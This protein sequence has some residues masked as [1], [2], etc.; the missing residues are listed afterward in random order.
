[1]YSLKWDEELD[2]HFSS[3]LLFLLGIIIGKAIFERIPVNCF[4]DRTIIRQ[5]CNQSVELA[6]IYGY[7]KEVIVFL[8]FSFIKIGKNVYKQ[9][10]SMI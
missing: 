7:D 9:L 2:E 6:D 3:S 5:I 10:I 4:L 8:K 1:M